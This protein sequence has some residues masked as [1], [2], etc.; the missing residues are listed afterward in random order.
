[1][2]EE[3]EVGQVVRSDSVEMSPVGKREIVRLLIEG[4]WGG[5]DVS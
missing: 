1:M 3:E 5:D 2:L 4:L